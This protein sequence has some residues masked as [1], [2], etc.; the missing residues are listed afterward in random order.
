MPTKV[1]N[2]ILIRYEDLLDDFENTINSIKNKGL[3]VKDSNN[4]PINIHF[5]KKNTN[6]KFIKNNKFN[7]I[8]RDE[9]YNHPDFNN[10][11]E[12]K[13]NYLN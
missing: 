5:Y 4:F 9:I 8:T 12:A 6:V 2:Y 7:Y 3:A 11:Y 1:K 13:L 10:Y